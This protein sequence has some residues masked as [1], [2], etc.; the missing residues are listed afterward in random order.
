MTRPATPR[1][2]VCSRSVCSNPMLRAEL[3]ERHTDVTFNEELT[4][5]EGTDL[6]D[7]MQGF[8]RA[9]IGLELVDEA[10]LSALPNLRVIAK[11][12]VGIDNLDLA[13]MT[14]L[15]IQL[16]WTGGV[17]KRSVSELAFALMIAVLRRVHLAQTEV[18]AGTWRQVHG[19]QLTGKTVGIIGCGH[20]GKDLALI[21]EALDCRILAHDIRRYPDFYQAHGVEPVGIEDLL[22]VSDVVTLHVP[23]DEST[24]NI[25]T[26]ERLALMKP[27]AI[28]VNTARGG[29]VD[30]AALKAMLMDGRLAGAAFDVFAEEPPTDWELLELP[31][32][33]VTGHIGGSSNEATLAMGRAAIA[34]LDD[35]RLPGPDWPIPPVD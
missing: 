17:N 24:R 7:F 15:G 18:R 31:N 29:L 23:C 33:L 26:A 35:F 2:V 25:L 32:F 3:L 10:I 22:A 1:I 16:G 19:L 4:L 27:G 14:R 8:E 30:E 6:V 13:A 20:I 11:Y 12:G 9:V 21:L 28:L 34:G 5:Y